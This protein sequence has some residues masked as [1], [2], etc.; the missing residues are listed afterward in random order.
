MST[1]PSDDLTQKATPSNSG[2]VASG[3]L[4]GTS[5]FGGHDDRRIK[6]AF[7]ATVVSSVLHGALLLFLIWT[8]ASKA[9][10]MVADPPPIVG[11]VYL[12]DPGPGGGGG[13]SPAPAPPREIE[14]PPPRPA[15]PVPVEVPPPP[16]EPPPVPRL[17]AP[18]MTP[19]AAAVQA[20]GN[21]TV[22]LAAYG[23]GGRG[24]GV[25]SGS[26][27]GVGPGEGGGTGGG[28]FGPGSGV[29]M[30]SPVREVR[31]NYTSDAMRLKIQGTVELEVVIR[32]DGTVDPDV[33]IT[34]SLDRVHGLDEE[35]KKAARAWLF[36]PARDREGKAVAYRASIALDFRLH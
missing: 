35:A 1:A 2:V 9:A 23:G 18:V 36:R 34:K 6:R 33:R 4:A 24:R 8:V 14:I 19:N 32:S 28:I 13:G 16:V 10:E 12:N 27:D 11:L 22:S 5:V 25:G 29:S 31:P 21:N 15:E 3:W 20:S 7:G 17:T 30:P 26:G